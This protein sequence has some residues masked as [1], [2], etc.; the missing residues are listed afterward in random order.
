MWKV[1]FGSL[2]FASACVSVYAGD[3]GT[4][5][6]SRALAHY[7]MAVSHDLQGEHRDAAG[8]Y[9]RAAILNPK[10]ALPHLHLAEH[11]IRNGLFD[12]AVVQLKTVL[13]LDP[14]NPQAHYMLALVYSSQ[15]KY[16]LAAQEYEH[17]LQTASKNEPGNLE[18]YM[19]LA[20]LY[21]SQGKYT[22]AIGQFNHIIAVE[23]DNVSANFLMGCSYLE[24]NQRAKARTLFQKVLTLEPTQDGALNSLAYM[25][26][27]DGAN[28]DEALK[29]V[30]QAIAIAPAEGAYYDTLGWV[31]FKK[32]MNAEAIAALQ[33]AELYIQSPV[34]ADHMGDVYKA[35]GEFAMAHK[36]WRKSLDLDPQQPQVKAKL[37]ELEKTQA[38]TQ[39]KVQL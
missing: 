25:Y 28:L 22:Q 5:T 20:Q 19:Y 23:P 29:M 8:E 30:R 4:E 33:K 21:F 39:A 26:A 35:S 2:A 9:E 3:T 24:I 38:K 13:R 36:S 10:E 11:A 37:E 12:K 18:I 27:Q 16:D 15:K 1:L 32:G 34:I 14:Q 17:I 7:I 6:Q 31:L